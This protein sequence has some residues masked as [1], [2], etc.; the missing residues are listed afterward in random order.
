MV[1]SCVFPH[2]HVDFPFHIQRAQNAF[3]DQIENATKDIE[4]AHAE[5]TRWMDLQSPSRIF[6]DLRRAIKSKNE[7]NRRAVLAAQQQQ[8]LYQTRATVPSSS[9]SIATTT[10]ATSS[11][12]DGD[13]REQLQTPS[14][15]HDIVRDAQSFVEAPTETPP[16]TRTSRAIS[17]TLTS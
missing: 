13:V 17:E 9:F 10:P 7:I 4:D 15:P 8:Q 2:S 1:C 16:P 14:T 6:E 5:L 11:S 3:L 12:F